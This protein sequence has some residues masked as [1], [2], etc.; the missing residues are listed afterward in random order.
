MQN[1]TQLQ[2]RKDVDIDEDIRNVRALLAYLSFHF[3]D[4]HVFRSLCMV[5]CPRGKISSSNAQG[6][7]WRI[8]R[9][10]RCQDHTSQKPQT[11]T[12]TRE[13]ETV[14]FLVYDVSY[15]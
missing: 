1:V 10:W 11:K 2:R 4:V 6:N 8:H 5:P 13:V 7:P 3:L 14:D 15:N 9:A 12:I